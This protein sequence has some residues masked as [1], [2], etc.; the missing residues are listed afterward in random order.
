MACG[1]QVWQQESI[2]TLRHMVAKL[3]P[4]KLILAPSLFWAAVAL[5][6][7]PG[8]SMYE[9][10]VMLFS[11]ILA[12]IDIADTCTQ[13]ILFRLCPQGW[14]PAYNGVKPLIIRG[15][16]HARTYAVCSRLLQHTI[17]SRGGM[18]LDPTP[19][20]TVI[21][22]IA[23]TPQLLSGLDRNDGGAVQI[24]TDLANT[25]SRRGLKNLAQPLLDVAH[26]RCTSAS[27]LLADITPPLCTHLYSSREALAQRNPPLAVDAAR[28]LLHILDG[29]P[30][31]MRGHTLSLLLALVRGAP[32]GAHLQQLG[33]PFLSS[34]L[35]ETHGACGLQA[36]AIM[37]AISRLDSESPDRNSA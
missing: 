14:T 28:L 17:N 4:R 29:G 35:R 15:L 25:C 5:L 1:G 11:E 20:Y 31:G 21:C 27:A 24:A 32:S 36:E 7:A 2:K 9:Q 19:H 34:L 3:D 13:N 12:A 18:L 26:G 6:H 33:S 8:R 37:S 30:S 23:Q 22:L 10:A 16:G